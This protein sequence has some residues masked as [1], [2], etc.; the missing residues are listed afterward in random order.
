MDNNIVHWWHGIKWRKNFL[1]VPCYFSVEDMQWL[2]INEFLKFSIFII[3]KLVKIILILISSKIIFF[4]ELLKFYIVVSK[5]Q[6]CS[7]ASLKHLLHICW[8]WC[9]VFKC[10]KKWTIRCAWLSAWLIYFTS[11]MAFYFCKLHTYNSY[12]WIQQQHCNSID[13]HTT[14]QLNRL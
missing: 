14:C 6:L 10:W 3:Y 7:F 13:F 1:G 9:L 2:K 4:G 5:I 11:T 12:H 8:Y